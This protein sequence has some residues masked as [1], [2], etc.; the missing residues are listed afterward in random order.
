MAT[1]SAA[2]KQ[3]SNLLN[4]TT[5]PTGSRSKGHMVYRVNTK[6]S[7]YDPNHPE[8]DKNYNLVREK[9]ENLGAIWTGDIV[10]SDMIWDHYQ[11]GPSVKITVWTPNISP[12][13][14]VLGDFD[15]GHPD[16]SISVSF[17]QN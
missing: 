7:G 2:S 16:I 11:L 10:D 17:T 3:F 5:R 1:A 6:L 9:L 8:G 14:I 13:F 12:D 4:I 15:Q